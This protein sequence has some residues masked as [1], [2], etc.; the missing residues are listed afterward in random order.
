MKEQPVALE[1]GKAEVIRD[2]AEVAI[3]GLGSDVAG[4]GTSGGAA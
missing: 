2:G 1:I 4:G 3:F